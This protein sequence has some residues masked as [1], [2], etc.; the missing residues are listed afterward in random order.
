MKI[1]LL[2]AKH[3]LKRNI[4][5]ITVSICTVLVLGIISISAY[6][7]IKSNNEQ[8]VVDTNSPIISDGNQSAD[9]VGGND[10][11]GAVDNP[12]DGGGGTGE[13]VKPVETK[14]VFDLPF[15]SANIMKNYTD[16][17]LVYDATTNLWCTHQAIDF[18]AVE[19]QEM[20]AVYDGVISKIESSM[21]YGTVVYLQV[22]E[23][24]MVVYRGLISEIQVREGDSIK[25][26]AVIGKITSFLAEKADGIHLHLEVL[27]NGKLVN[28]NEYFLFN[29]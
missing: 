29:K 26:G 4:Y 13:V 16:S 5:P 14:I 21:M 25:K 2:K 8:A 20:K 9:I 18:S 22:S 23:D 10:D 7:A 19:G 28:P 3:F 11:S 12:N 24:L 6:S 15:E 1:F 17:N 27:K